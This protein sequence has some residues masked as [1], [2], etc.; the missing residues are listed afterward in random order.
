M[1]YVILL[2]IVIY[3]VV[4]LIL[5]LPGYAGLAGADLRFLPMLNAILN[6]FTTLFLVG[7]YIAIRTKREQ[8]HR[9]FI[10]AAF[11]S[12]LLFLVSYITYHSLTSSTPYGGQGILRPI[13]FFVLLTHIVLA[14]GIV[15]FALASAGYGLTNQR[16]QHRRI[17]RW[18]MPAWLYVSVTGVIVYLMIR[19]YYQV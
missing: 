16:Q 15:P 11:A 12:T 1:P 8:T 9:R 2:S 4:G 14:A 10:Y 5:F 6:S 17:A 18:T 3:A 7:A 13:Y 19:P